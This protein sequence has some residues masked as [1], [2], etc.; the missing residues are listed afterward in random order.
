MTQICSSIPRNLLVNVHFDHHHVDK[1]RFEIKQE[2][3]SRS[4]FWVAKKRY[5]QMMIYKEGVPVDEIDVKGL[6]VVRSDFPTVYRS[7]MEKILIDILKSVDKNDIDKQIVDFKN[8][9]KNQSIIDTMFNK[10]VKEITKFDYNGRD[11]FFYLKGTPAHIKAAL[12]YNDLLKYYNIKDISPFKNGEKVKWIY[13][14][15]NP[16]NL[17]SLAIRGFDDPPQII[18]LVS[19][20]VDHEKSFE[21]NFYNKVQDF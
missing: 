9:L 12:N 19:D 4:G 17:E 3:I 20:Y 5:A 10:A 16:F 8:D 6:D 18:K 13:L 2:V 21:K 11:M 1:H 15:R 14:K 7:F